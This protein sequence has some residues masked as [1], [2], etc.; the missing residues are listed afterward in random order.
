M[1][2]PSSTWTQILSTSLQNRTGE[3]SDNTARRNA[4]YARMKKKGNIKK[5]AGGESIVRPIEYDLNT[6]YTRYTNAGTIKIDPQDI[7]TSVQYPWRQIAITIQQTGL[8]DIQNA[9]KEQVIDLL[10]TKQRNAEKSFVIN[11]SGDL[12]SAG[13]ADAGLQI[14]GLQHLVADDPTTSATVGGLNQATALT[15][16]GVA[17]WQNNVKTSSTSTGNGFGARTDATNV[18]TQFETMYLTGLRDQQEYDLC[19]SDNSIW[20]YYTSALRAIQQIGSE[21]MVK[22]GILTLKV[23]GMDYIY[24]GGADGQCPTSRAYFLNTDYIYLCVSSKRDLVKLPGN[25]QPINQDVSIN[26]LAWAGNAVCTNRR[27]EAVLIDA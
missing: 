13:T 16:A 7:I 11:F 27:A 23:F 12:Y 8:E 26:I 5:V 4:L 15:K 17:F 22:D 6:N 1:A 18:R 25:R 14:G 9:G 3:I 24:D 20:Q 19:V 21:E 2:V 10:A